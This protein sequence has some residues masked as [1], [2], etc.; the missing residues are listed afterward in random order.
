MEL[1]LEAVVTIARKKQKKEPVKSVGSAEKTVL[2]LIW[3][4]MLMN[5]CWD[6]FSLP[7]SCFPVHPRCSA[8]LSFTCLFRDL[9]TPVVYSDSLCTRGAL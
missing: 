6:I 9:L 8:P 1:Q 7:S 5:Q 3:T 2:V 4:P